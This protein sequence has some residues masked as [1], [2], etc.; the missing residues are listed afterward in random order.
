MYNILDLYLLKYN[1]ECTNINFEIKNFKKIFKLQ[2]L[3][4]EYNEIV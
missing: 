3:Y 2:L 1:S 4:Y